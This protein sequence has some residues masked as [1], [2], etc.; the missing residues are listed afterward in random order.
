MVALTLH[1]LEA[2]E[3][4]A[5]AVQCFCAWNLMVRTRA[6]ALFSG[7]SPSHGGGG[8]RMLNKSVSIGAP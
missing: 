6:L 8:P 1:P 2:F 4:P 5:T 7:S 3:T